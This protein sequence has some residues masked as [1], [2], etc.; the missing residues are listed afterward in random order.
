M[1][2]EESF[3]HQDHDQGYDGEVTGDEQDE[4]EEL[5]EGSKS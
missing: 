3:S 5:L 2:P 1:F 4:Q